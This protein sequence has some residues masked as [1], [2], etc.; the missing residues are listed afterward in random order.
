VLVIIR[1]VVCYLYC[2]VWNNGYQSIN[3]KNF[4]NR[5]PRRPL[6]SERSPL[7]A[8][9]FSDR[10]LL[11]RQ[12]YRDCQ[13]IPIIFISKFIGHSALVGYVEEPLHLYADT[14]RRV[15]KKWKGWPH[16]VASRP[17]RKTRKCMEA[18]F[19]LLSSLT[20]GLSDSVAAEG[21]RGNCSGGHHMGGKIITAYFY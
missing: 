11:S 14:G 4:E 2:T 12:H 5:W 15:P 3:T 18:R 21:C 10:Q 16:E 6:R 1:F 19:T 20:P 17:W 13:R 7:A 9:D 8:K